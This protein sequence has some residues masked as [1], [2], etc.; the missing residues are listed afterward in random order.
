[1]NLYYDVK[2]TACFIFRYIKK[3][4]FNLHNVPNLFCVTAPEKRFEIF[5][6]RYDLETINITC[7]ALGVYPEPEVHLYNHS[8]K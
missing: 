6:T 4:K 1:M 5:H 3:G 7:R 8:T 2:T